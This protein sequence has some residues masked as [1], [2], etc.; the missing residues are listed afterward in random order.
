MKLAKV[1]IGLS[2]L[3]ALA[4]TA[5]CSTLG[6][7]G[8]KTAEVAASGPTVLNQRTNPGTIEVNRDFQPTTQAEVLAEVQDI[9]SPVTEVTLRFV[10]VPYEVKMNQVSGTT[11]RAQ[12]NPGLLQ[13]LA[14]GAQTTNYTANIYATD[15]KGN[16]AMS[17]APVKIAI[18]APDL[19]R[20][21]G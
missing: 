2:G 9:S 19:S 14:I 20:P 8:G 10:E 3:L 12:L 6:M 21:I 5:G 11:W 17:K 4:L 16:V 18:K 7:G 13:R 15:E 1:M